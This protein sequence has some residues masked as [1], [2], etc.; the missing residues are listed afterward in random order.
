MRELLVRKR[1]DE[2]CE[3]SNDLA[4]LREGAGQH[5]P[6][7][8]RRIDVLRHATAGRRETACG[9]AERVL[10]ERRG[11]DDHQVDGNRVRL[12]PAVVRTSPVRQRRSVDEHAVRYDR[13]FRRRRDAS[14]VTVALSLG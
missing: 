9:F 2:R 3:V 13:S 11:G 5:R 1:P 7:L 12:A 8:G 10:G 4:G 6:L 14:S